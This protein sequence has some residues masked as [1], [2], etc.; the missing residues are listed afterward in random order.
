VVGGRAVHAALGCGGQTAVE[1]SAADH[2]CDFD[3]LGA[4]ARDLLRECPRHAGIDAVLPLAHE[5]L[6]RELEQDAAEGGRCRP[7][8]GLGLGLRRHPA[9]EKRWNSSTSAPASASTLPTV[10][11]RSWIHGWS[12][13][14]PPRS[15]KKRLSSIPVT[16]FSRACSGFDCTSSELR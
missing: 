9:R 16:I 14:P 5:R 6:A 13:S 2:D 4:D 12:V 7:P 15:A 8:S 1:V 10:C 3:A 11:E